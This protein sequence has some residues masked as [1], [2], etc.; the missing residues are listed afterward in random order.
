MDDTY[1]VISGEIANT[2]KFESGAPNPGVA[3]DVLKFVRELIHVMQEIIRFL[4][5]E[6]R[7]QWYPEL[8]SYA[9]L[10]RLTALRRFEMGYPDRLNVSYPRVIEV[11]QRLVDTL[12]DVIVPQ[13][14]ELVLEDFDYVRNFDA[15]FLDAF[16]HGDFAD[17][18]QYPE[19]L[20]DLVEEI[21][22]R[23]MD[24]SNRSTPIWLSELWD[25]TRT[26]LEVGHYMAQNRRTIPGGSGF[27]GEVRL[28][29]RLWP[30]LK[31]RMRASNPRL[32]DIVE[33]TLLTMEDSFERTEEENILELRRVHQLHG[34]EDINDLMYIS[35]LN[36]RLEQLQKA[37][38]RFN[39]WND[40]TYNELVLQTLLVD[41]TNVLAFPSA[42]R[43][44]PSEEYITLTRGIGMK[45]AVL[46]RERH[47][48]D[49][50]PRV[51]EIADFYETNINLGNV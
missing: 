33:T 23:F 35:L 24:E 46:Y 15:V 31:L 19:S 37:R 47:M 8:A 10:R 28:V 20:H 45:R 9:D 27:D 49:A 3:R 44:N 42:V 25:L 43:Q 12:R 48:R 21:N 40:L 50:L 17:S 32:A 39:H 16:D 2:Q 4:Q 6:R 26:L 18:Q 22:S 29:R 41:L 38:Q 1:E 30:R 5:K 7:G 13:G 34:S 14:Q 36:D 11:M 51:L